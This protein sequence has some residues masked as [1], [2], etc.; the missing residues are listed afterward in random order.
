MKCSDSRC[1]ITGTAKPEVASS[2]ESVFLFERWAVIFQ[3]LEKGGRYAE[4]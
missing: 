3:A 2:S 1:R 4:G